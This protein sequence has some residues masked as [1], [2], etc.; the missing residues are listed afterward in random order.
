MKSLQF[1]KLFFLLT[2]FF[3]FPTLFSA[4]FT[5]NN[6]TDFQTA[7][8]TAS[9]N[10]ENDTIYVAV[11][12]YYLTSTITFW[13]D[14]DYSISI[15]GEETPTFNGGDSIQLM[16][17]QTVAED[18]NINIDGIN[19]E[20]GNADYGAALYLETV[21]ANVT[22]NG[23]TFNDNSA[24]IVCGGLNIYSETG[25]TF[26]MNC[27][28]YRNSSPNATGYP[29]GTA[30]GLFVQ[31]VGEGT[32][33]FVDSCIF[34][35][36]TAERDGAGAMLYPT[37]INST[38]IVDSCTFNNN[39]ATEFGG[40]CWIRCPGGSSTIQYMNNMVTNNSAAE[41]G[42]GGGTYIEIE[43]GAIDFYD[44]IHTG[45]N[46][47]WQ[48]GA[49]WI[50]N[51]DG[52]IDL[53]DNHFTDNSSA[54]SGGAI[55]IYL[56]NGTSTIHH[57]IINENESIVSGGGLGISTSTGFLNTF[58]NTFFS[59][60]ADDGGDIYLY[61]EDPA[62]SSSFSNN[63]LYDS[64]IPALSFSGAYSVVATYSDIE[65]GSGEPW[66]G[67]GCIELDPLFSNSL[68]GDFNLTVDSPCI[69]AG[70][71]SSPL[72]PDGT[73]AD[74]GALYFDQNVGI[75]NPEIQSA[76]YSLS[77]YPNP[78]NPTTTIEFSIQNK[79]QINLSIYNIKGQQIK[80]LVQ[81]EYKEGSHSISWNGD[82]ESGKSVSSGIYYYKLNVNGKTT[83]VKK[84]LLLK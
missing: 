8:N 70:D 6:S 58:S 29:F 64:S 76:V 20:H 78:F 56:E 25:D 30:G 79:S 24:N 51:I 13:S 16:S 7:M 71:P 63:I 38:V 65:G 35:E 53:H 74:M 43:S 19:F 34:E 42:S 40:G 49:L 68:N 41:T 50:S 84:C 77:N 81:N 55:N 82:D 62:S 69:D 22:I 18:G 9:F 2:S 37:S 83:A 4:T 3:M 14:E 17:L 75:E 39:T 57:N 59:N 54:E 60:I 61:F 47:A 12:T 33:I 15:I 67:L 72:D 66:F 28:F 44:N 5:V 31:T 21:S 80:T 73:V 46:A 48:G 10:G 1:L 36:N 23:C 32:E 11:G 45:N 27:E 26:V 52:T